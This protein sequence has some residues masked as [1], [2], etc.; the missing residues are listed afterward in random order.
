MQLLQ[1]VHLS[2]VFHACIFYPSPSCPSLVALTHYH[3]RDDNPL[4]K[5]DENNRGV[6]TYTKSCDFLNFYL[7]SSFGST[8]I[9]T[10]EA[11]MSQ[12]VFGLEECVDF[13]HQILLHYSQLFIP[14]KA[15]KAH[16]VC[17]TVLVF[18][19]VNLHR[20]EEYTLITSDT[21]ILRQDHQLMHWCYSC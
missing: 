2:S 18:F 14:T 17:F 4:G 16:A 21:D 3:S 20:V 15:A 12:S 6:G 9:L 13:P 7:A 5:K 11:W 1:V 10:S 8:S 19:L